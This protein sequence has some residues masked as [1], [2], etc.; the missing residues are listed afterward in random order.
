MSVKKTKRA[1]VL[2][3]GKGKVDLHEWALPVLEEAVLEF[4]LEKVVVSACKEIL[5]YADL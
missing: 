2:K 3:V 4:P 1:G 5:E